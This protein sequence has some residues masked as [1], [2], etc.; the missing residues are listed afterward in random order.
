LFVLVSSDHTVSFSVH[1]KLSYRRVVSVSSMSAVSPSC[2]CLFTKFSD[3]HKRD[4]AQ[5]RSLN[6]MVMIMVYVLRKSRNEERSK[7]T[8][9]KSPTYI[10]L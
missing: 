5:R 10:F 3:L 1:V 6:Y 9:E 4:R 8:S 7:Y 2:C